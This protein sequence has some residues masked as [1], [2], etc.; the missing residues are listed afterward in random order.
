[1][2]KMGWACHGEALWRKDWCW[3]KEM[4]GWIIQ[5]KGRKW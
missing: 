1:M 4:V 5:A 2:E 3:D